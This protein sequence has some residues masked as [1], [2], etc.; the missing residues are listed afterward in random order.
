[1]QHERDMTGLATLVYNKI[2][3]ILVFDYRAEYWYG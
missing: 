2:Y 3:F 1:M